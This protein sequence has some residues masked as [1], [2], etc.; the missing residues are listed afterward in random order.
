ME[1]GQTN[2]VEPEV[3]INRRDCVLTHTYFQ[4]AGIKVTRKEWEKH[5]ISKYVRR[6]NND[7]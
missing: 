2:I 3:F 4:I 6:K 5:M 7:K 1:N